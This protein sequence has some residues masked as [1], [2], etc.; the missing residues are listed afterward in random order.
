[1]GYA[2]KSMGQ[3]FLQSTKVRNSIL[4]AA[5]VVIQENAQDRYLEDK[6]L[7][8]NLNYN[9]RLVETRGGLGDTSPQE[10]VWGTSPNRA[11]A[12]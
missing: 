4:E 8:T 1:M 12:R 7:L 2:K 10:V 5:G 6:Q 3:N 11:Y 9:K